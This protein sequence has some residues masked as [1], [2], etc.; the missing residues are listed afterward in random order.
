MTKAK[1]HTSTSEAGRGCEA[2]FTPEQL[3]GLQCYSAVKQI[4]SSQIEKIGNGRGSEIERSLQR[5]NCL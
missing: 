3:A 2:T 4:A 1:R 5:I